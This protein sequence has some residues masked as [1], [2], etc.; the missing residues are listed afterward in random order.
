[1]DTASW[2][3]LLQEGSH[4]SVHASEGQVIQQPAEVFQQLLLVLMLMLSLESSYQLDD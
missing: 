4:S 1:M 3:P 2:T